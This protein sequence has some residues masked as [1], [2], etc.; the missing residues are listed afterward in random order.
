MRYKFRI[1]VF[2]MALLV[3][4]IP[5]LTP[6]NESTLKTKNMAELVHA[7]SSCATFYKT[8][9]LKKPPHHE[10]YL[11]ICFHSWI[12]P[13]LLD[14]RETKSRITQNRPSFVVF[15]NVVM[16]I[17]FHVCTNTVKHSRLIDILILFFNLQ[18]FLWMVTIIPY[19][20]WDCF[21]C[22]NHL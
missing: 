3:A 2:A 12:S 22:L 5:H 1:H 13:P 18:V 20:C 19:T 16:W 21:N 15:V 14:S 17:F 4:S 9:L 8:N 7:K 11:L 10:S 6:K